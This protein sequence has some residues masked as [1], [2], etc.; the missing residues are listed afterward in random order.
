MARF[1]NKKM[2]KQPQWHTNR[3]KIRFLQIC[4]MQ[5]KAWIYHRPLSGQ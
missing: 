1:H 4:L 2:G 3:S 5:Q